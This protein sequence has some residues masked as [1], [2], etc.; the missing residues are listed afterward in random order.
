MLVLKFCWMILIRELLVVS[1]I[2]ILGYLCVKLI[3][4][5]IKNICAVIWVVL[6][7]SVFVGVR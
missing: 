1:L 6:I 3:S 2:L 4:K 5:D 7:L